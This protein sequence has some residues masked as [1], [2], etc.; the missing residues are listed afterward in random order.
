MITVPRE[1]YDLM[2][3]LTQETFGGE[4]PDLERPGLPDTPE[5]AARSWAESVSDFYEYFEDIRKDRLANPRGDLVGLINARLDN[6]CPISEHRQNHLAATIAIAGHDTTSS[7]LSGGSRTV[8]VPGSGRP[9]QERPVVP[10][11]L[12]GRVPA[13][14]DARQALHAEHRRRGRVP[15]SEIRAHGPHHDADGIRQPRRGRLPDPER[16]D[17]TRKPNKQISFGSAPTYA[18]GSTSPKTSSGSSSKNSYRESRPSNS[19]ATPNTK[20][21][22]S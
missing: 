10:V 13:L 4:D 18:S 5:A 14:R 6:G 19:L 22:T 17:V 11:R 15:R 20:S 16:F 21:A 12:G 7:A 3:R 1:D 8:P 9:R 2:M